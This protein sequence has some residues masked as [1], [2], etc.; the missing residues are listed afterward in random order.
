MKY[1]ASNERDFKFYLSNRHEFNFCGT[2][3]ADSRFKP[4]YDKNGVDGKK[5][6]FS[7]ENNGKNIPTKHP[8]ILSALLLSKAS[9]NFNI[10][11]WAEGRAEGT[12]PLI[13][14]SQRTA[15][16]KYPHLEIEFDGNDM[17]TKMKLPKWVVTAVENS[18][19][20]FYKSTS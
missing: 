3:D 20:Q 12:L 18:K 7:I 19:S 10:K 2:S 1:S 14:F 9:V 5:A 11:M 16:D 4:V 15:I 6:F 17:E 13:E 8:N